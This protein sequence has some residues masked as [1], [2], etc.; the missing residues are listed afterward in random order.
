MFKKKFTKVATLSLLT[1]SLGGSALVVNTQDVDAKT[2]VSQTARKSV[3]TF[4]KADLEDATNVKLSA[5]NVQKMY[6]Y[7]SKTDAWTALGYNGSQATKIAQRVSL[8]S[9][10]AQG[11]LKDMV[12]N[13]NLEF[14]VVYMNTGWFERVNIGSEVVKGETPEVET[15]EVETPE[16][17]TPE[18]ET[19]EVET[20]ETGAPETETPEIDV[21][22][23]GTLDKNIKEIEIEVEYRAKNKDIELDV[24]VKKDGR[25]KAEFEN[26]ATLTK[27]KGDKA[28]AIA[29]DIFDGVDV[30]TMSKNDIKN[31][32]LTK[33]NADQNVKKFDFKV[34]YFDGSKIDFKIK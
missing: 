24:D 26:E 33:L 2:V 27:V 20:P 3:I 8:S 7:L 15:P 12:N 34:K 31:H 21:P 32:V 30:R 14:K 4:T 13:D 23:N 9:R 11:I 1:I 16:V 18:V 19:P 5:F 22:S 10:Q 29:V 17:E 28:E 6:D 25:V